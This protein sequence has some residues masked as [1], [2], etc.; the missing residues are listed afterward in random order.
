MSGFDYFVVF[1]AAVRPDGSPSDTLRRRVE[2]A[3]RLA[4]DRA[5]AKF[6]VTGGL[7]RFAPAEFEVMRS[8][9]LAR[10]V[11]GSRIVTEER[12][13]DTLSSA[14]LC[15]EILAGLGDARSVT[16]CSS[17]YHVPRC[18]LLLRILGVATRTGAMASE[19]RALGPARWLYVTLRESAALPWDALLALPH[20][21]RRP[22]TAKPVPKQREP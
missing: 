4:G 21:F 7:G 10:G 19:R 18:R 8:L 3:H 17:R 20:R 12:A 1:G 9:L 13:H 11:P 16:V 22:G 5:D 15:R 2:N 6:L 14:V